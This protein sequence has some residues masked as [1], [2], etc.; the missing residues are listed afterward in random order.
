MAIKSI[1]DAAYALVFN[2][3]IQGAAGNSHINEVGIS[4]DRV[5]TRLCE[6][7]VRVQPFVEGV[8]RSAC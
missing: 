7:E 4:P 5:D 8:A 2:S 3:Q 6:R 1:S